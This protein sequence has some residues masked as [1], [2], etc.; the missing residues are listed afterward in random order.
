MTKQIIKTIGM[1]SI[2]AMFLAAMIT[3][4]Q[5]RIAHAEMLSQNITT[6]T[7]KSEPTTIKLVGSSQWNNF[8]F[9]I[10]S[11]ASHGTIPSYNG[12]T[13]EVFYQP[14]AG[15]TGI[16]SFTYRIV[17]NEN[18][19][20]FSATTTVKIAVV[21]DCS[22]YCQNKSSVVDLANFMKAQ[23]Y[24]PANAPE[25]PGVTN[26]EPRKAT[27]YGQVVYTDAKIA[28][29][30]SGQDWYSFSLGQRAYM[31][32]NYCTLLNKSDIWFGYFK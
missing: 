23:Q 24:T 11:M 22:N 17:S 13:G 31:M 26:L 27:A 9:V 25:I 8:H 3:A 21:E 12:V 19:N 15:F 28:V 4:G 20:W 16:D 18:T 1:L 29:T 14:T 30:L 5:P 6:Y 10:M 7:I 32:D 2:A